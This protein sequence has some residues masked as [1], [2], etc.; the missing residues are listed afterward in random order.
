VDAE[1][2]LIAHRLW[3]AV[4][5]VD[6]QLYKGSIYKLRWGSP[7]GLD[8]ALPCYDRALTTLLETD[9]PDELGGLAR[10]LHERVAA[11]R[12]TLRERDVTTA[13]AQHSR[14]MSAF[15]ALRESVRAWPAAPTRVS[16][17]GAG[18]TSPPGRPSMDETVPGG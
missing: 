11:Y 14:M 9:W 3:L 6:L 17:A 5:D 12:G 18:A 15:D 2:Q 7:G 4:L 1:Q 8:Q 10:D 13:S 16:A